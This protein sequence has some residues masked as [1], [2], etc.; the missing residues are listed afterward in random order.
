MQ[1]FDADVWV[2]TETH[3]SLSPGE[4]F[5]ACHGRQRP[6]YGFRVKD[7]SRWVSIWSRFPLTEIEGTSDDSERTVAALVEAPDRTLIV[8]GTVLPWHGD[9]GR[10]GENLQAKNWSEHHRVIPEQISQWV[11]LQARFP[12]AELCIAGDFNTDL[13]TGRFYGTRKGIGLLNEGF[14]RLNLF[15]PSAPAY[16]PSGM[17]ARPPIDHVAIPA[18]FRSS[19]TVCAAFEGNVGQPRLSDHSGIVVEF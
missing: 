15:C 16:M 12:Q 8:Y 10:M 6:L 1:S 5:F 18:K 4:E 9:R 7:G 13:G 14:E 17:L 3:D 2:L 11:G 19:A